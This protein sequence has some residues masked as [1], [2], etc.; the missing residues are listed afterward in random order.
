MSL[1]KDTI[2]KLGAAVVESTTQPG[3]GGLVLLNRDG[4]DLS[5]RRVVT[6]EITLSGNNATVVTQIFKVTGSVHV[7]KLYGV[8]T[9]VLGSNHTA[10]FWKLNDGTVT[11]NLT[12]SG[13]TLSSFDIDS[14][15]FKNNLA[16]I[17]ANT[18]QTNQARLSEPAVRET[19]FFSPFLLG[20]KVA[21]DTFVEYSYTTTNTPTSGKI[22]FYIEYEP[23]SDDGAIVAA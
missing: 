10:G 4:S 2:G 8:V 6:K 12:T 11:V 18:L 7:T 22:K 3:V 19:I 15:I 9:Q 23:V 13:A 1:P 14:L 17:A 21:V 20:Q 16:G 5:K